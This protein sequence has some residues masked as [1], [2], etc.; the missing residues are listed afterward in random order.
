[1]SLE[2]LIPYIHIPDLTLIPQG[3]FSGRFPPA[4]LSLKPFG[5]LV[6]LGVYLSAYLT[7]RQAKRIGLDEKV[8]TTFMIWVGGA[9]FIGGHMLDT[10]F[11]YP[12]RIAQDPLSLLRSGRACRASAGSSA[13]P[14][15]S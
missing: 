5:T 14:S 2:P 9:G 8:L 7:V 3:V 1:M 10:L 6:A 12:E 4:P 11:Y 13:R 15:A